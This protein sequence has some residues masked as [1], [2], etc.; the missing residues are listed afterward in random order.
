ME[1]RFGNPLQVGSSVEMEDTDGNFL[2]GLIDDILTKP[3]FVPV[4]NIKIQKGGE[5]SYRLCNGYFLN[6]VKIL[7]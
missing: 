3:G 6:R 7:T 2:S 4:A 5:V 1:D